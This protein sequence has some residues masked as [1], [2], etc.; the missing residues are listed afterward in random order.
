MSRRRVRVLHVVQSLNYGGMERVVSDLILH[1]DKD[2]FEQ[3]LLCLE[4][5]G[6]FSEGLEGV[7]GLHVASPMSRA[8][9]IN[10]AAL[11]RDI[12]RI[13]PDVVH[14]HSGVWYKASRA[15][16]KAG[17]RALI[18][19]E[20]GRRSP[21][22]WLDRV[23]DGAAARR[24]DAIVAVSERLAGELPRAL[25]ASPDRVMCIPTASIQ[26]PIVLV[27]TVARSAA[28]WRSLQM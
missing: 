12:A 6:R 9:M 18:H 2:R 26:R 21:D 10:P 24:T 19:T 17:V 20:H 13:A 27:P 16:R 25:W 3:H 14:T 5:L 8:S 15:A 11:A 1:A 22:P 28:S 23:L 4:Y 7:A